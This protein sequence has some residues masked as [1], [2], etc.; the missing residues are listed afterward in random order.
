MNNAFVI[1]ETINGVSNYIS[2]NNEGQLVTASVNPLE[3]PGFMSKEQAFKVIAGLRAANP[4]TK[5]RVKAASQALRDY[6]GH[7]IL[8]VLPSKEQVKDEVIEAALKAWKPAVKAAKAETEEQPAEAEVEPE[9]AAEQA[10]AEK[11]AKKAAA[12]KTKK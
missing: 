2:L 11:P 1:T 5:Y 6:C 3:L 12:K 7:L 9:V 8:E 10:E 4:E